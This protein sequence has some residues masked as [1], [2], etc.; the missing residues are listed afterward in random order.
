MNNGRL[1]VCRTVRRMV[2]TVARPLLRLP[3]TIVARRLHVV[4]SKLRREG[5]ALF[6]QLAGI[7]RR[8]S[9]GKRRLH[10]LVSRKVEVGG[11]AN[12]CS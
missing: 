12:C 7:G 4:T 5:V 1:Y 9:P 2:Q 10:C 8:D 11:S 6:V 3:R